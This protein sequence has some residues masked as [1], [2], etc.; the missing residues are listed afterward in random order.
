M[1]VLPSEIVKVD[2]V[3]GAVRVTL[4]I[5]VAVATPSVGVVRDGDVCI[6]GFP[7]PVGVEFCKSFP[8]VP[9][10]SAGTPV[11]ADAGPITIVLGATLNCT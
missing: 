2:P 9:L 10:K 11:V 5:V 8:V 7:V 3:A 6:T 1:S 4:F